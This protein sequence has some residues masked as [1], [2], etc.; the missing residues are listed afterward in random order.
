MEQ[1]GRKSKLLTVASLS[2]SI[3]AGCATSRIELSEMKTEIGTIHTRYMP[4]F[5]TLGTIEMPSAISPYLRET[6]N[7]N[8]N[9][10]QSFVTVLNCEHGNHTINHPYK[11][12]IYEK[13]ENRNGQRVKITYQEKYKVKKKKNGEEISRKLLDYKIVDVTDIN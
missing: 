8:V 11:Y 4:S 6:K 2:T 5:T 12:Q 7:V 10:S 9:V 3:L 13:Y 1:R